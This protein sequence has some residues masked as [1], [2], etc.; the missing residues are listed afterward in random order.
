MSWAYA[1]SN[2]SQLISSNPAPKA[3]SPRHGKAKR[4]FLPTVG[5]GCMK[6]DHGA[7]GNPST[8]HGNCP[9]PH[10][11]HTMRAPWNQC[12]CGTLESVC[13]CLSLGRAVG[14]EPKK[15]AHA[16]LVTEACRGLQRQTKICLRV[17][18]FCLLMQMY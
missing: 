10:A 6:C 1:T 18:R 12:A 17:F 11:A 15:E 2:A 4:I 8:H 16:F 3:S 9:S 5:I 14:I 13:L 7:F